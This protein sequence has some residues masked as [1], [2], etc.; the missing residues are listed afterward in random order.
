MMKNYSL[1]II[2]GLI[3]SVVFNA[4]VF[5][6]AAISFNSYLYLLCSFWHIFPLE[7]ALL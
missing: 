5:L 4:T 7:S 6:G 2:D 3:C 1:E